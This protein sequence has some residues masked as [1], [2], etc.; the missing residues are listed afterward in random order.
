M[1][2]RRSDNRP[3]ILKALVLHGCGHV[4][5]RTSALSL[6]GRLRQNCNVKRGAGPW[7]WRCEVP[8]VSHGT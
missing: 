8:R 5:V 3:D 4:Q 6:D 1:S 7:G 2:L